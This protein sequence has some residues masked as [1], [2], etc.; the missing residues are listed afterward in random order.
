MHLKSD[1]RLV[2]GMDLRLSGGKGHLSDYI[3]WPNAGYAE[4]QD[5]LARVS[6]QAK[7]DDAA[8]CCF[9]RY[10]SYSGGTANVI[11]NANA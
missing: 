7:A 10:F 1:H 11:V 3:D 6:G 9:R 5:L 8:Y 2:E 4:R